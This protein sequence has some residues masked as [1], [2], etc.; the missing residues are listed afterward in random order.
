MAGVRADAEQTFSSLARARADHPEA[1]V[2]RLEGAWDDQLTTAAGRSSPTADQS[3]LADGWEDGRRW[4]SNRVDDLR[5]FVA[6]HAGGLRVLAKALR[7]VG[8]ALVA[9]GAALA[10]LS[11]AAGMFSWGSGDTLD[12]TVDWAEGRIGGRELAFRAG[13]TARP[14]AK[15]VAW[16]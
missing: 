6:E 14:P 5:N 9:V 7:W 8:M 2:D 11:L 13:F 4:L 3:R 12:T 10:V 15:A 1:P 16:P